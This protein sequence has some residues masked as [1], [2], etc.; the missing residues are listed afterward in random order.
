[1]AGVR[2]TPAA[3]AHFGTVLV[4]L[5]TAMIEARHYPLACLLPALVAG[6]EAGGL[7]EKAYAERTTPGGFRSSAIYGT[8]AAAAGKLIGLKEAQPAAVLSNAVSFA[9][10][11][12][13]RSPT[14]PTSGATS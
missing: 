12:C 6:Y 4:P 5:L 13:S 7:L 10:A 11:C 14:A 9:G 1:M 3:A 2:K 8:I